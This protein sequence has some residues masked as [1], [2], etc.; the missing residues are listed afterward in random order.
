MYFFLRVIF[1]C[2]HLLRGENCGM[3]AYRLLLLCRG[4]SLNTALPDH[5][6]GNSRDFSQ[7]GIL[8]WPSCWI[9]FSGSARWANF[10]FCISRRIRTFGAKKPF[11]VFLFFG[12]FT[13]KH[14]LFSEF[15]TVVPLSDWVHGQVAWN[16]LQHGFGLKT[17]WFF[18]SW[19]SVV[20]KS[21]L[22]TIF[23]WSHHA[24]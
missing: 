17:A 24:H 20:P 8:V 4:S 1:L 2:L 10:F 22:N 5:T 14:R 11:L 21:S 9:I 6:V 16:S 7:E 15:L 12:H 23:F 19:H 18:V 3:H 13:L